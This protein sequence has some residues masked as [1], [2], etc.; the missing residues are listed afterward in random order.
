MSS[1]TTPAPTNDRIAS[2]DQFRGYAIFG[3]LLVNFFGHYKTEWVKELNDSWIKSALEFIFGQQLHH[4]G[5]YMTYADTIAPIFMF[6]VGIGMR[7]SWIRRVG[8]VDSSTA[9]KSMAKR[10]FTLVLIAFAIYTGWLW[11]ALMNIGLAG[12]MAVLIVDKKWPVRIAY[13]L[14][15]VVA[16]QLM[17]SYTSYGELM[18]RLGKYGREFEWP[19]I[20]M[21][22]PL[23]GELLDV[24]INGALFGHWS[25]AFMLIFGTIAYDI[26]ATQDRKK[27][28]VG[29]AGF[30]IILSIAGWVARDMGTKTYYADAEPFAASRMLDDDYGLLQDHIAANPQI[31]STIFSGNADV[32]KALEDGDMKALVKHMKD[33]PEVLQAVVHLRNGEAA[34]VQRHLDKVPGLFTEIATGNA[35]AEAALEAKDMAAFSGAAKKEL[36]VV[37]EAV[38]YLESGR[39]QVNRIVSKSPG[40][41][42]S[43]AK[44][45]PEAE[46]ALAKRDMGAFSTIMAGE[47]AVLAEQAPDTSPR[48]ANGWVF[49][50]NYQTMPFAF[51]ATA[52]CLF[53][54]L[55][56]YVICDVLKLNVPTMIVVGLNPLFI[57]IFQS[58]TLDMLS[59]VIGHYNLEHTTSGTLVLGSFVVY[60]GLIYAMARYMYNRNIIVKI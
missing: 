7:I 10:Y 34:K 35:A 20:S 52:L 22:L 47:L 3:M 6:V 32:T 1:N 23:R 50:K 25:W 44:G 5:E 49:S 56:F 21:F 55:L 2:L 38:P 11:D 15:L 36:F 31:F 18:L 53:H 29:L 45:N 16:Y 57:Y 9:R 41:F 42:S 58:L 28:V 40:I 48:L 19:W 59:N 51:W 37:A 39:E 4:H 12:L 60:Y 33:K 24:P 26:M 8:K 13:A 27:I 17:F 46:A 30:G 14:G 43:L 54:L